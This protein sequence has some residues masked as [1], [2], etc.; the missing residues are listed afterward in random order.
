MC[1]GWGE[2]TSWVRNSP[3]AALHTGQMNRHPW[4]LTPLVNA[5]LTVPL[6]ASF[7]RPLDV[8]SER[9]LPHLFSLGAPGKSHKDVCGWLPGS[10]RVRFRFGFFCFECRFWKYSL[11]VNGKS[12]LNSHSPCYSE[13]KAFFR[14]GQAYRNQIKACSRSFTST[15]KA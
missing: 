13:I 7:C 6:L 3:R 8:C 14:S 1:V 4:E 10:E 15:P 2:L 9:T 11:M 5:S 12:L